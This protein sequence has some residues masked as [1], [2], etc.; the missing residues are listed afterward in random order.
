MGSVKPDRALWYAASKDPPLAFSYL[1]FSALTGV[2]AWRAQ[3]PRRWLTEWESKKFTRGW[4]VTRGDEDK[5]NNLCGVPV[6]S[7][8]GAD[9]HTHARLCRSARLGTQGWQ[10][11]MLKIPTGSGWQC[12]ATFNRLIWLPKADVID[13]TTEPGINAIK[14]LCMPGWQ[15]LLGDIVFSSGC[16]DLHGAP[17]KIPSFLGAAGS[18]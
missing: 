15:V 18:P 2:E 3:L 14:S 13:K 8:R 11:H 6:L 10:W 9:V 4:M 7:H 16:H 1:I 12:A 17:T 5:V